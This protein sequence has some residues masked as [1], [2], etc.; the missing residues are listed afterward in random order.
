MKP[1]T[2][3]FRT[4]LNG[5]IEKEVLTLKPNVMTLQIFAT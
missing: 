1:P 2:H 4:K 5:F 3:S